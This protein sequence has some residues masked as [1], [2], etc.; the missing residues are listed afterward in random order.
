VI[1]AAD[2]VRTGTDREDRQEMVIIVLAVQTVDRAVRMETVTTAA[3]RVRTEMPVAIIRIRISRTI[4]RGTADPVRD[5]PVIVMQSLRAAAWIW[6]A[7]PRMAR[8]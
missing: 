8:P 4:V 1:T 2:R 6:A 5:V 7:P 3:V